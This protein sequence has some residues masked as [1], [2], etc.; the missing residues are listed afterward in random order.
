LIS[1]HLVIENSFEVFKFEIQILWTD[2][3]VETIKIEVV[4][5][6]KVCNFTDDNIFNWIYLVPQII[7][8]LSFVI[9][10]EEEIL[11]INISDVVV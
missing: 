9:I 1:N 7:Q 6:E 11:N 2:S 10:H 3:D 4:D 5:L 8:L